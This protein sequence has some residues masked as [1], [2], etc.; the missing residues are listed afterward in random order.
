MQCSAAVWIDVVKRSLDALP[1]RQ[2]VQNANFSRSTSLYNT[3]SAEQKTMKHSAVEFTTYDLLQCRV[4][5]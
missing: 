1:V 3:D 5:E 4:V 2:V